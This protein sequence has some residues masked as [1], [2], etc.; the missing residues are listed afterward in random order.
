[1]ND[2]SSNKDFWHLTLRTERSTWH[3]S[4][5][6]RKLRTLE[7]KRRP[8]QVR[9]TLKP[10]DPR[11]P[12]VPNFRRHLDPPN[13]PQTFWE[14]TWIPREREVAM[15]GTWHDVPRRVCSKSVPDYWKEQGTVVVHFVLVT[16]LY[17][18]SD[19]TA[20]LYYYFINVLRLVMAVTCAKRASAWLFLFPLL[21]LCRTNTVETNNRPT[22]FCGLVRRLQHGYSF[23]IAVCVI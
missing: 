5:H 16:Y 2:S 9:S 13:P 18:N 23:V 8:Y 21:F 17:I 7:R 10:P 22:S 11:D 4:V 15:P 3:P 20:I 14:G 12:V 1:M 6:E 19:C